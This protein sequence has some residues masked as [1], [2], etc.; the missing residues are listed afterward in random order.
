MKR[1][2]RDRGVRAGRGEG[3]ILRVV[4]RDR[5]MRGGQRERR[6]RRRGEPVRR[7]V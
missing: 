4:E 3:I 1:V 7:D 6:N 2:K 5:T